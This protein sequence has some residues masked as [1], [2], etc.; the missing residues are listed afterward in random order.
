MT[1]AFNQD[2]EVLIRAVP[3]L[4][5]TAGELEGGAPALFAGNDPVFRCRA[6]ELG[7]RY[8][9]L[10]VIAIERLAREVGSVTA[11]SKSQTAHQVP[12]LDTDNGEADLSRRVSAVLSLH[13]EFSAKGKLWTKLILSALRPD[14][15]VGVP[16]CHDT[17]RSWPVVSSQG[18]HQQVIQDFIQWIGGSGVVGGA[19][20]LEQLTVLA[21]EWVSANDA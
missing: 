7:E 14:G 5:L 15:A 3:T 2:L 6:T 4:H 11:V 9:A 18:A 13:P 19:L 21:S 17:P 12:G 8:A 20:S 10:A 1:D 16:A